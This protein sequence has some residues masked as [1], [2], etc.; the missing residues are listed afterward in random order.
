MKCKATL[1]SGILA[2]GILGAAG[3]TK[4]QDYIKDPDIWKKVMHD[5][6]ATPTMMAYSRN[7]HENRLYGL[8]MHSSYEEFKEELEKESKWF[9][10]EYATDT[11]KE[12]FPF[13]R[14][15][16]GF[17][18]YET[19]MAYLK[20]NTPFLKE[21]LKRG[22]F[23]DAFVLAYQ[24]N[25][26]PLKSFLLLK[27]GNIQTYYTGEPLQIEMEDSIESKKK[28]EIVAKTGLSLEKV[29]VRTWLSRLSD[30]FYE[31]KRWGSENTLEVLGETKKRLFSL[32][33]KRYQKAV[34]K[35]PTLLEKQEIQT[36][37]KQLCES[38]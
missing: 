27:N 22:Y 4:C 34:Q 17:E 37:E 6:T 18:D 35:Y 16:L 28:E 15:K 14:R 25:L 20:G 36:L 11:R 2:A 23:L 31:P 33:R 10:R 8:L 24:L 32:A 7:A 21:S 29:M 38:D 1:C 9:S 3:I 5:L 30:H 19:L 12:M 26:D 13:G